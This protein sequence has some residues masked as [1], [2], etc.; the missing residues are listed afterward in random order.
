MRPSKRT[1]RCIASVAKIRLSM[2]GCPT[3]YNWIFVRYNEI[4]GCNCSRSKHPDTIHRRPDFEGEFATLPFAILIVIRLGLEPSRERWKYWRRRR[5]LHRRG[6]PSGWYRWMCDVGF[7][8]GMVV[9]LRCRRAVLWSWSSSRHSE[10][11]FI[12]VVS[13]V[14]KKMHLDTP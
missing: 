12:V 4:S 10:H 14:I 8:L 13:R 9:W 6:G 1:N 11:I 3:V 5:L 2:T 7:G